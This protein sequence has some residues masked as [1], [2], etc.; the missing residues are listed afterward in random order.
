MRA[1]L[2]AAGVSFISV[3]A[4]VGPADAVIIDFA[5]LPAGT[6][7]NSSHFPPGTTLVVTNNNVSHPNAAIVFDSAC[8][9]Q[10]S[11]ED[12]DL[13]TPSLTGA[14]GNTIPQGKIM[15]I[16]EDVVDTKTPFGL[17]D[18]PDDELSGGTITLSFARPHKLLSV[19]GI[20]FEDTEAPTR[21]EFTPV[22]G[23]TVIVPFSLLGDNS[24]ETLVLSSPVAST[25]IRFILVGTGGLDELSLVAACGDSIVDP[26]EECDPPG[27][28]VGNATCSA[29]CLLVSEECGN[30]TVG[31]GE[32]CDP[33]A[34]QGGSNLECRDDCTLAICG[35]GQV[36]AGEHCD[37][38]ESQGGVTGCSDSCLTGPVCGDL[39][40][41]GAEECDPPF[42][43]GG[44][45]GC[46]DDCTLA[47]CGDGVVEA[48]EECDPTAIGALPTCN[49]DCTLSVCG[50]DE[51]EA[52]EECD[53]PASMNGAANCSDQC[54][55]TSECGNGIVEIGEECDPPN[56]VTCDVDCTTIEL[57]GNGVVDP[58]EQCDPPNP[59]EI[60]D[61]GVDDDADAQ[62]DCF[63]PD[64]RDVPQ[65]TCNAE[66]QETRCEGIQRDPARLLVNE[67]GGIGLLSLHGR[68]P[69]DID[70]NDPTAM[71]FG[72]S[73]ANANGILY[74][75]DL[76]AGDLVSSGKRRFRYKDGDARLGK[77]KRSGLG[78]VSIR[79]RRDGGV[80]YYSFTIRAYAD[81]SR[82]TLAGMTIQIY[83][84]T[85]VGVLTADWK[86]TKKG[87]RLRQRDF[88]FQ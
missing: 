22:G 43:L 12:D 5:S 35:D 21:V 77:G 67:P 75:G 46:R 65:P 24:A 85:R 14:T 51:I 16:A 1:A 2:A 47:I 71:G 13:R 34:S 19:R 49:L 69:I 26:G 83:T 30:G 70:T 3:L 32:E 40:T 84:G 31:P 52:G 55:L 39:I 80:W 57:C 10:C 29:S 41:E 36:E 56:G 4:F 82:A 9:G 48:G 58:G 53:P 62:I 27:S 54:L 44:V 73:L 68:V 17:V 76:L 72:I 6:I 15:I 45:A 33:P 28:V 87:W 18:D 86:P 88:R 50:D 8:P 63:D 23:G 66:C 60:C 64:C 78:R 59:S 38:P 79:H 20:D 37:P 74:R 7:L 25:E 42:S 61:N 11:G 81:F